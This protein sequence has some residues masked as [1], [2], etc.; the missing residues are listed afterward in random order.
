MNLAQQAKNVAAAGRMGDTT[1]LH[2][3]PGELKG[4]ASMVPL[5]IN[6]ETGHAEAFLPLLIGALA[7]AALAG[8][9]TKASGG[10]WSDA[11]KMAAVGGVGG[12]FAGPAIAGIAAPAAAGAGAA[13]PAVVGAAAPAVAGTA[14]PAIGAGA[15]TALAGSA[16]GAGML[17]T[18][19]VSGMAGA[20]SGIGGFGGT[21]GGVAGLSAPQSAGSGIMGFLGKNKMS[22]AAAGLPALL[23]MAGGT[24]GGKPPKKKKKSGSV[25][26]YKGERDRYDDLPF[27]P[28]GIEGQHFSPMRYTPYAEGGVVDSSGP[29]SKGSTSSSPATSNP[30][31]AEL[32]ISGL[33]GKGAI[34]DSGAAPAVDSPAVTERYGGALRGGGSARERLNVDER[35]PDLSQGCYRKAHHPAHHLP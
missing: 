28:T 16:P 2:L 13:A 7:G 23:S 6:P 10:S 32:A 30:S 21:A 19:P 1:L 27:S 29:S 25:Q 11:L 4:L 5:T 31:M 34:A 33:N 3:N 22:L 20:G 8:G 35:H 26:R 18:A 15:G 9:A 17:A 24:G 14:A 12:A